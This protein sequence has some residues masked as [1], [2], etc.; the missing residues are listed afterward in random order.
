MVPM[1]TFEGFP[2]RSGFFGPDWELEDCVAGA[3][4]NPGTFRVPSPE[5]EALVS[6]GTL[7]RLH[8][9][10]TDPAA[11]DDAPRAERMWVEVC[12]L[13]RAGIHRGHL[14]NEPRF[15]RSLQPGDV[16]EFTWAHV[17]QVYVRAQD[18]RHPF[19]GA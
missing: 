18:P 4:R 3:R 12:A 2:I 17:A 14:T 19:A 10:V 8:F 13:P 1:E 7:L 15:I 11:G 16:I 9:I 6:I 5:E